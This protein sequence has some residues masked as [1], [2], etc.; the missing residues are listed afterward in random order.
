M[1]PAGGDDD[2]SDITP[3]SGP[4]SSDDEEMGVGVYV[5]K[6]AKKHRKKKR[7]QFY[8]PEQ[9]AKALVEAL[10]HRSITIDPLIAILPRLTH[11]NV[12]E[13]RTE[14]KK[15]AK[16][17][18]KGINVAKHI[19]LK[20]GT[21]PFG[22]V[23]YVTALGQWESEAYWANFWYQTNTTRRELLIE[24]LMGRTNDEI[25]KIKEAFRD[26]RY[27]DSL[28]KCMKAELK[29]DKFRV[30]VLQVLEEK[31]QEESKYV[32]A[33]VVRED[34]RR[35]HDALVA[36]EGGET[37][38]IYIVVTRSD[39]HMREVLKVYEEKYRKNF[40]KEM[41]KK[42]TNLVVSIFELTPR[43]E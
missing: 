16:T 11:E 1:L 8:D 22:K 18:G 14:Y 17:Q 39:M 20:L 2:L 24:S 19:K 34:V 15:Y 40:A 32:Y 21:G 12:M 27:G 38:M 33:D 4:G 28:E 25:R 36:R 10:R 29:A 5:E 30:A 9:D 42:S 7:V 23:C 31:R 43:E 3:L 6:K 37:A 26:K 35:L 41:L 13:L